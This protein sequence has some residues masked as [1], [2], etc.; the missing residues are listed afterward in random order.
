MAEEKQMA[1]T[2]YTISLQVATLLNGRILR[3]ETMPYMGVEDFT[4]KKANTKDAIFTPI[5]S[6]TKMIKLGKD[7][8]FMG[9]R[10]EG[11]AELQ[12]NMEYIYEAIHTGALVVTSISVNASNADWRK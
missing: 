4:I 8:Y 11:L 10:F 7:N 6:K 3:V 9:T 5:Y 1:E 12:E 2:F